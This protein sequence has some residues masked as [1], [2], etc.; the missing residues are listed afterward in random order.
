MNTFSIIEELTDSELE[1]L[2]HQIAE[3]SRKGGIELIEGSQLERLYYDM[4]KKYCP[5]RACISMGDIEGILCR[6][7]SYRKIG[8]KNSQIKG[9]K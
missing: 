6:E 9:D 1:V 5:N 8:C 4:N 3:W 7:Y 2:V